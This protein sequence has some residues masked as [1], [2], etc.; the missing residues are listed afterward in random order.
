[1]N[2]KIKKTLYFFV[3]FLLLTSFYSYSNCEIIYSKNSYLQASPIAQQEILETPN[4]SSEIPIV[5]DRKLTEDFEKLN[6]P[7]QSN[8]RVKFK[9]LQYSHIDVSSENFAEA[10]SIFSGIGKEIS[11]HLLNAGFFGTIFQ[12][13]H[14]YFLQTESNDLPINKK[15]SQSKRFSYFSFTQIIP[16]ITGLIIIFFS[17][18]I[19]QY[20]DHKRLSIVLLLLGGFS[21]R[22]F[23]ALLNPNL[24][25][26]DE[27]FHALV[28]KNM[29]E[30]PFVPMLYKNPVIPYNET[31]WISGHVWLHKQ[32]LFLWQMAFSMKIFG[33]NT[34]ALRLPSVIMSTILILF[35]F[36]IGQIT[37]GKTAGYYSALFFSLSNFILEISAGA[38]HTDHN[39]VAFLFYIGASIWAW[40]EYESASNSKRKN[41]FLIL[42]GIFVGC[43]VLVKWLTGFLVFSGWGLSVLLI[44]ERRTKWV[45]YKNMLTSMLVAMIIFIPWQIYI[46]NTFPVISK[47]EFSLNSRHFFEVIENHGGDF[48]W[49]FNMMNEIYGIPYFLLLF[50][51]VILIKSITNNIYK[52]SFLTIVVIIYT[53]FSLAATKMVAFTLPA[54]II[55]YLA[56]GVAFEKYLKVLILNPEYFNRKIFHVVYTTILIGV[57]SG[58]NLNIEKIQEKH[59]LWKKDESSLLYQ[60]LRTTPMVKNLSNQY[61][62]SK[63]YIIFNCR[64]EDNVPI[65]FFNDIVAAYNK[66]PSQETCINLKRDGYKIAIFDNGNLPT[67][68]ENDSEIKKIY[69]YWI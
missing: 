51:L 21:V 16:L 2:F 58:L 4:I 19:F 50:F 28:A 41:A 22:L 68:I 63:E 32:P 37:I 33:V 36:R 69:G 25:F 56:I 40:V 10:G 42:I 7:N 67:Y 55:L 17:V 65:M 13:L 49:H 48:F 23:T 26:W 34:F 8:N 18:I 44:K 54:S 27:Q 11:L 31:S 47:F 38:I 57:L 52:I 43:S 45:H 24:E 61:G 29:M 39:D 59:T 20:S 46:I 66:I 5:S 14:G 12:S 1:M 64:Q 15:K 6:F 3:G 9:T 53:F 35:I 62:I 60:R 30:N